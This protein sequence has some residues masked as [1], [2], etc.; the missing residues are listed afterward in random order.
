MKCSLALLLL[1]G[2]SAALFAQ[3]S[4]TPPGAPAPMM[5]TLQ[6]VEPRI[7]ISGP[8]FVITNPGSYYVTTNIISVSGNGITIQTNDV[9]VDLNGFMLLG[10]GSAVGIAVS[11]ART[12]IVVRNGTVR[13]WGTG[14]G[15]M[16]VEGSRFE[17]LNISYN[18]GTGL[19]V[20]SFCTIYGCIAY[21]NAGLGLQ[22]VEGAHIADCVVALNGQRG[23]EASLGA[24]IRNCAARGN[25]RE[26]IVA[27]GGSVI[28]SCLVE[29]SGRS[30]I[31][32]DRGMVTG[33]TARLNA[34]S[35]I[36]A[37]IGC[38]IIG[39]HCTAN[40]SG[41]A[42][43]AGIK[44]TQGGQR[45]EGNN[46]IGNMRG[47]GCNPSTG[48]LIIR[49]TANGNALDYDVVAGNTFGPIVT[50]GTIATNTNPHANY[51]Y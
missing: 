5:K 7:P 36:D 22:A 33:C 47:I 1:I 24:D 26:G 49:N 2:T 16:L 25:G 8:G 13:G 31:T 42:D 46:V 45:I 23:I 30:G 17:G 32:I 35:G 19:R 14:I 41:V 6:Q 10:P 39:N 4:L 18:G 37:F 21:T 3:G 9:T 44:S 38:Q 50:S 20:G 11:A 29:Y 40:G 34:L 43:S 51:V 28:A 27:G 48:N 12:N 15:A